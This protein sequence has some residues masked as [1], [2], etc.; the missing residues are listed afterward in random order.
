MGS[1]VRQ[2]AMERAAFSCR[3]NTEVFSR[4]LTI[5]I[6][7]SAIVYPLASSFRFVAY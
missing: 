7:S 5:F 2:R 6:V 4:R 1:S 3:I